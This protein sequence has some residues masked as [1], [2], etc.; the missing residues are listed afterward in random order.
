MKIFFTAPL[1]ALFLAVGPLHAQ[2]SQQNGARFVEAIDAVSDSNWAEARRRAARV[3]DPIALEIIDWYALRAGEGTFAKYEHFL[4]ENPDWPD[5]AKIRRKAEEIMPSNLPASQVR[6]FF[7]GRPPLTGTGVLLY[8]AALPRAEGR[9]AIRTAWREMELT[10]E[11]RSRFLANYRGQL[12]DDH[13]ARLDMLLWARKKGAVR[14]MLPL[15]SSGQRALANARLALQD[16]ANGV[17]GLIEAIPRRLASSAGLAYDRF[18]WRLKKGYTESAIELI[19]ARSQSAEA[20]GNPS[21]W[22]SRRR[23]LARAAMRNGNPDL[24]YRI[25]S[26]HFLTTGSSYADLEWLSGYVA[27]RKLNQP[28]RALPHFQAFRAAI[29]SPISMGRAGYWLGETFVALNDTAAA[30]SAFGLGAGYQTSFYGQLAASR[31][32]LPPDS[33]L[34]GSA[35]PPDWTKSGFLSAD[36]VRAGV[37]FFF[38]GELGR[39]RQFLTKQAH[40]LSPRDQAALAQMMLDLEEPHLALRIAKTAA[41]NGTILPDSYY[42]LHGLSEVS[43]RVEPA[44]ALSIARQESEMNASARS[45]VG[46][47]GL[48]QV[49]PATAKQVAKR[50]SIAYSESRLSSDWQYNARLGTAYLDR[51]LERFDG[52][53]LL[54]AAAYNAG[55]NRAARWVKDLGDPRLASVDAVDWIESIPYRET[56]NYVMRV[57]E[58]QFVYRARLSGQVGPLTLAAELQQNQPVLPHVDSAPRAAPA[59]VNSGDASGNAQ[60]IPRR[61]PRRG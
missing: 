15:V 34:S 23:T 11:E 41:K 18:I 54:A 58:A 37:L 36:L 19:L 13:A 43:G 1:A 44:L 25:A 9:A 28:R 5:I 59:Q 57:M 8:A 6:A 51:V 21:K 56:R 29:R 3:S 22:S 32:G 38:A 16:D 48:M 35:F 49:M 24:A 31:A 60:I 46:A 20:L 14:E 26:A 47:R 12:S 10:P 33:T 4:A 50:L 42:P 40:D 61:P 27:L 55:P 52:S 53:V 45:P 17:D 30:S 2:T 39:A 7:A